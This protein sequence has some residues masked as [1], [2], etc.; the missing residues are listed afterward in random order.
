MYT[1]T[2]EQ[3][4]DALKIKEQYEMHMDVLFKE[5]VKEVRKDLDEYFKGTYIKDYS[6]RTTDWMNNKGVFIFPVEPEFDEDYD[7]EFDSDL[8]LI[9]KKH[10]M[11][12]KMDSGIYSK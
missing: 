4:L 8:E 2:E 9:A 12:V 1:P 3:Y 5:K 7:G 11:I 10:N 6:V